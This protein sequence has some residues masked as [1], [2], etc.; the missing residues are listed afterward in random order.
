[1]LK[2]VTDTGTVFTRELRP[3]VR[4]PF[5][6]VFGLVQPLVFLGLFGPLLAGMTGQP[7][8]KALQW[9]VPGVLVMLSLFGSSTTGA[10]LLLEMQTGSHERMLVTP[11]SRSSLLIGRALKEIAPTV[12]QAALIIVVTLPFG[13]RFS[14]LGALIGLL[15]LGVFSIGLGALSHSLA[16]AVKERQGVFW[17]VQQTLL[18]P[19]LILAGMLLPIDAGPGWLRIAALAN[20][21]TYVVEA[22]RVLFA[23]TD[24]LSGVVLSGALAA[25]VMAAIG[26]LVGTTAMRRAQ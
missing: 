4:D 3:L 12:A 13:F 16:L 25:V 20:P 18:F 19:M 6:V 7:T 5:S 1:M 21:L 15:I 26:L 11:L 24:L 17:L 22:Q 23:G 2:L 14:P 9:F 8:D 10:N